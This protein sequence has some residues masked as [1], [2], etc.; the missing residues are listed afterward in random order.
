V[1]ATQL[2]ELDT[3]FKKSKKPI[4]IAEAFAII[5]GDVTTFGE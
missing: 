1:G 4:V 5:A 2:I 3:V